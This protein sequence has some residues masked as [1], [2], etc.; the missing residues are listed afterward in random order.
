MSEGHRFLTNN[1]GESF[2]PKYGWQIDPFGISAAV[3][4]MFSEMCFE[5][6]TIWRIGKDKYIKRSQEKNLEF[7]WQS[8]EGT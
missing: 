6:N 1:I 4:S 7:I 2:T 5:G 3:N 8:S